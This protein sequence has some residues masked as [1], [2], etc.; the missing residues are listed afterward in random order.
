MRWS[1][2][3]LYLAGCGFHSSAGTPA[4]D[5][6]LP[7]PDGG[8]SDMRNLGPNELQAGQLVNMT[9]D[10]VRG[11]LT[12]N[13]YTYGG[14]IAHGLPGMKLWDHDHTTWTSP[15]T[16][17]ATVAGLWRGGAFGTTDDLTYVGVTN[18]QTMTVWFEGEV[19]L[20]ATSTETFGLTADDVAFIDLARPGAASF[21]RVMQNDVPT[22]A[23]ATPDT[24]WYPIR[25]GF[26]NGDGTLG[27][28]FTHSDSAAGAQVAWT[29]D[30]L[31]ARASELSGAL[32]TVFAHQILGGGGL[33][34]LPVSHVDDGTLIQTLFL[35]PALQGAPISN[36]SWSARYA[37]QVY[38]P[39]TDS[40]TLRVTSDDGHELWFGG[41]TKTPNW[42]FG[43]S[44]AG[45]NSTTAATLN[46]GWNDV[47][48]DY[49]QVGGTRK[50]QVTL[51]GGTLNADI[52]RAMLRPVEPALDRLAFGSDD[53]SHTV[54]DNG[55]PTLP[56][57]A[58]MTVDAYGG[59]TQEMVTSID[60]TYEVNAPHWGDLRFDLE[61]PTG[62]RVNIASGGA[63]DGDSIGQTSIPAGSGGQ[64]A[65][66]LNVPA[67]GTWKLD[68]YDVHDS[69]QGPV[70]STLKSAKLTLHTSGGPDKIARSASWTSQV[71]DATSD[72]IAIDGI[73]WKAR[74]PGGAGVQVQL[75][76][77]QQMDCS[78][79]PAWSGPVTSGMPFA[80][81]PARYLQL[82]VGMTSDG[83]HEPEL[84]SL[85]LM[86]RRS[87]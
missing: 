47:I 41:Q 57:T 52:P 19:W 77:C 13:A 9:F 49:N 11:S 3:V 17:N 1:C 74:V 69:G 82:Q 70:D 2:L 48:V 76:G 39:Q 25:I 43:S 33:N 10:A 86:F 28:A 44:T 14:L 5:A 45:A 78:D 68:C 38:V 34:T 4:P 7:V 42:S 66:L 24:G 60:V 29:R 35:D 73:T 22:A 8:I 81:T 46:A 75:R 12:P 65:Q 59:A 53:T 64:L 71:I 54:Q 6:P 50:L 61:T 26:A 23:V 16:A 85:A 55:G 72:V 31:R 79:G 20:D 58:V 40:Y 67:S 27:F 18:D 87:S 51:T 15:A 80:I 84:Q 83:S 30:R 62:K 63:P 37:A 56:G 21:T 32:R 36:L